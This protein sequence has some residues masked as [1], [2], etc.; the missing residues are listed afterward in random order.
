MPFDG[1]ARLS[2]DI[3]NAQTLD[4]ICVILDAFTSNCGYSAWCLADV[5]GFTGRTRPSLHRTNLNP[6][7]VDAY[8]AHGLAR[9]DPILHH[10]IAK[11]APFHWHDMPA[12][13]RAQR[14]LTSTPSDAVAV[15]R[16]AAA[17]GIGDAFVM[18]Y[19][20]VDRNGHAR[21]VYFAA[22]G[23][24]SGPL[25]PEKAVPVQ[26]FFPQ[27]AVRL[28]DLHTLET[29]HRRCDPDLLTNREAEVLWHA[30]QGRDAP[31]T[32]LLLNVKVST[33]YKH[34]ERAREKMGAETTQAAVYLA[35]RNGL[36]DM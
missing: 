8:Y 27:I 11:N 19:S 32:A 23:D 6:D 30:A 10:A 34:R 29:T 12:W 1:S 5:T 28:L 3:K 31:T 22:Y 17:Y 24:T 2:E 9:R 16:L 20:L 26:A 18:P 4:E 7:V 36:I 15:F 33:V 21:S 35:I 13:H 14:K 25:T